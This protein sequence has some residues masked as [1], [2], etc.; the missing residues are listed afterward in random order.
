MTLITM[1]IGIQL[2]G[3]TLKGVVRDG[4]GVPIT[5]AFL[6]APG[7][8]N[9]LITSN[10]QGEFEFTFRK[11]GKY[12]I[13]ISRFGF[14]TI[15]ESVEVSKKTQKDFILPELSRNINNPQSQY[16][17]DDFNDNTMDPFKWGVH[18]T[19]VNVED[20][21][22]KFGKLK[23]L[24][25]PDVW[26]FYDNFWKNPQE[27]TMITTNPMVLRQDGVIV[28]LR[29]VKQH[30]QRE[31]NYSF[32]YYQGYSIRFNG[33]G[34]MQIS[35][36]YLVNKYANTNKYGVFVRSSI[37]GVSSQSQLAWNPHESDKKWFTELVIVDTKKG[38]V[39]YWCDFVPFFY[40][41]KIPNLESQA[42]T[43]F[44]VSFYGQEFEMDYVHIANEGDYYAAN[45]YVSFYES[46][47]ESLEKA[48]EK[49]NGLSYT[50]NM[51]EFQDLIIS[52][53]NNMSD[54][55]YCCEKCKE[56][57]NL[58]VPRMAPKIEKKM[59]EVIKSI[60]DCETFIKY[61]S[62]TGEYTASLDD[63]LYGYVSLSNNIADCDTYLMHFP[64]GNHSTVVTAQRNEIAC[65]NAAQDGGKAECLAYLTKYPNGRF[66]SVVQAR[67]DGLVK[68]E[69]RQSQ[70][71]INSNKG[72]WKLGN[73]LCNCTKSGIIMVTLDQWNENRSSFK[74]IVVA[75]PGGSFQG[76]ILQKGKSIWFETKDWHICL[77]DEVES[78]LKYDKSSSAEVKDVLDHL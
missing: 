75:S 62:A 69:Q 51:V 47:S 17:V 53:I 50:Y 42:I 35:I 45:D 49:Y 18:G 20:G 32:H 73:K 74:G 30:P 22:L 43:S 8:E 21:L 27:E 16:L 60:S 65:F 34:N 1:I 28:I 55:I 3:A 11:K 71:K 29:K 14:Q 72:I 23:N 25:A 48:I 19:H 10:D 66:T 13:T 68:E 63:K 44:D 5:G 59:F 24:G 41:A 37:N 39:S 26:G 2:T 38:T 9:Y 58:D 67:K 7:A 70:I 56:N 15:T 77:D 40:P 54:A 4:A 12:E 36:N 31:N 76:N 61:Y 78:A 6:H 46:Q 52:K 33:K 64:N 57:N